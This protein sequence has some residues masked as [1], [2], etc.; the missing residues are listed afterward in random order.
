ML[1]GNGCIGN[2]EKTILEGVWRSDYDLTI[3]HLKENNKTTKENEEFL[4]KNLGKLFI[5]FRGNEIRAFFEDI[6]ESEVKPQTFKVVS[7]NSEF[8]ELEV[9]RSSIS[10]ERIK[11]FFDN[12]CIY[13]VQKEYKYN[14]YFCK[15]KNT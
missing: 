9:N 2:N 6:P 15:I 14:E 1:F 12:G 7:S 8:I 5:S 10:S 4:D 13:L 3:K 11:Y